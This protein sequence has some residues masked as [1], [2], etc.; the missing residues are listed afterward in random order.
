MNWGY[1]II[2][3]YAVFISGML[4]LAFKSTEQDIQLVTEDYYA[5]ELVYQQKIDEIKRTALLS[6]SLEL[7]FN[8]RTL[9][10]IFPNDF[11]AKKIIGTVTLYCPSDQKMDQHQSFDVNDKKVVVQMP[12]TKQ[13]L[14]YVKLSWMV[15]GIRYYY[16]KKIII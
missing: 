8:N 4:F 10:I 9:T 15:E 13:G 11:S 5:K 2:A 1:K 12:G 16:E 14:H 6:D 7:A 3:V